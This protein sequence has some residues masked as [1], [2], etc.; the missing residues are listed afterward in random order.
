MA[1]SLDE[2]YAQYLEK[3]KWKSGKK[4]TKRQYAI[5][6]KDSY[7]AVDDAAGPSA[8]ADDDDDVAIDLTGKVQDPKLHPTLTGKQGAPLPSPAAVPSKHLAGYEFKPIPRKMTYKDIAEWFGVLDTA[9]NYWIREFAPFGT[10]QKFQVFLPAV[11]K[12]RVLHVGTDVPVPEGS[13]WR[14][15]LKIALEEAEVKSIFTVHVPH[16]LDFYGWDAPMP[17][18]TYMRVHYEELSN[19]K[20]RLFYVLTPRLDFRKESMEG[21]IKIGIAGVNSSHGKAIGRLRQYLIAYGTQEPGNPYSGVDVWYIHAQKWTND[22]E[23]SKTRIHKLE[24]RIKRLLKDNKYLM[25]G[26]GTERSTVSIQQLR[27]WLDA[28]I[29]TPLNSM[30]DETVG[31]MC[32]TKAQKKKPACIALAKEQ[33]GWYEDEEVEALEI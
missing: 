10:G 13:A 17:L 29:T 28:L 7:D 12:M 33:E 31:L 11:K 26:R 24:L 21:L 16:A 27:E 22:V 1:K 14:R 8:A 2:A 5:A 30:Q 15:T 25:K 3:A 23:P 18:E 19:N 32:K 6:H 20:Q 9:Y 4:L